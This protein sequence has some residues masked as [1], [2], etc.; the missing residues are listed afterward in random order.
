MKSAKER[1]MERKRK[2][3]ELSATKT[4]KSRQR[5][6][7]N[8]AKRD[9]IHDI[10][11]DMKVKVI[12]QVTYDDLGTEIMV[13]N[14]R[15]KSVEPILPPPIFGEDGHMIDHSKTVDVFEPEPETHNKS[16]IERLTDRFKRK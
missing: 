9:A 10:D 15:I 2:N 16:A 3:K 6:L 8:K 1:K 11:P 14:G 5:R 13:E 4:V 12:D 7:D